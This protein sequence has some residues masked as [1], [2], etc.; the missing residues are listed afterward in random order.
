M[1]NSTLQRQFIQTGSAFAGLAVIAGA[2]GSHLLK[3][4]IDGNDRNMFEIAV[5]YQFYH[6]LAMLAIGLGLRRIQDSVARICLAFFIIGIFLFSGC[7]YL[8]STSMVWA[9]ERIKW[10]GTVVPFG[11][12]SFIIGWFYLT[13]K[14]YKPSSSESESSKKVMQMQKRK[15]NTQ[16]V[17]KE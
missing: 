4:L 1:T 16:V 12:L 5:R 2:F 14:G 10:F 13:W 6:A 7:L 9:G 17:D 11:G 15:T 3:E 8:Q